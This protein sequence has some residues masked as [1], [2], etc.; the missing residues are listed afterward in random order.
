MNIIKS[1]KK[2]KCGFCK[3]EIEGKYKVD[4][5][6]NIYFHLSCYKN[7]AKRQLNIWKTRMKELNKQKYKKY[8]ILERLK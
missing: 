2:S 6:K 5:N 7:C 8:M 4:V 3:K 1:K